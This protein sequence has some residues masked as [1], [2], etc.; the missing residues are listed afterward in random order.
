MME[1]FP[2]QAE[3]ELAMTES[4]VRAVV[5]QMRMSEADRAVF[6]RRILAGDPAA[7][8]VLRGTLA[9]LAKGGA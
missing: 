7:A 5:A 8:F 1:L 9:R 4:E 3:V 6:V 2:S